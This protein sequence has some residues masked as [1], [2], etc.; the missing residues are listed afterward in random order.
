MR[1]ALA[2]DEKALGPDHPDVAIDLNSLA[3]LLYAKGDY[4]EPCRSY[5]A[6]SRST[7]KH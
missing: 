4:A 1:R 7:R 2:I 6:L 3:G 5:G